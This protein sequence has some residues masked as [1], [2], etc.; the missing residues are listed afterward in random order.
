MS[1]HLNDVHQR[2]PPLKNISIWAF[3]FSTAPLFVK[4]NKKPK[5]TTNKNYKKTQKSQKTKHNKQQRQQEG[6][7]R[8]VS[9]VF[10]QIEASGAKGAEQLWADV[11]QLAAKTLA[12]LRP[13]LPLALAALL[14]GEASGAKWRWVKN[15]VTPKWLGLVNGTFTCGRCSIW[16]RS[17]FISG[18]PTGRDTGGTRD[19]GGS[20]A[21]WRS[22]MREMAPRESPHIPAPSVSPLVRL[23]N[24]WVGP[25]SFFFFFWGGGLRVA[26]GLAE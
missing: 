13:S 2:G 25:A 1:P 14:L 21:P 3:L 15:R 19:P 22:L 16:T 26:W 8:S 12:A 17:Q 6:S 4:S 11:A 5:N 20:H 18:K 24:S 9:S 23:S 10:W 7:K